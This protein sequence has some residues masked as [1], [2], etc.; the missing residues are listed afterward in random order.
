[1]LFRQFEE[2]DRKSKEEQKRIEKT[3]QDLRKKEEL[4]KIER[5][6]ILRIEKEEENLLKIKK[7][8][9][10]LQAVEGQW[11]IVRPNLIHMY[12][13]IFIILLSPP[14][15]NFLFLCPFF[16]ISAFMSVSIFSSLTSSFLYL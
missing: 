2:Q 6:R 4:L 16:S 13:H 14:F 15:L 9:A 5:E 3:Q 12:I 11:G 1:M 8:K 10:E 7:A